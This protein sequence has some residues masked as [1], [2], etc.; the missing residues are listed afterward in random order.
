M[1]L[2]PT[3]ALRG[4]L[5]GAGAACVW[6]AQQPLD[7]LIFASDYDDVELLGKL[8]TSGP[9][10]PLAGLLLHLQN[11]ALFGAVYASVAPHVPSDLD[12][13]VRGAAAGLA[14]HVLLWPLTTLADR[15]HPAR[16]QLPRLRGNR[17]AWWQAAWRHA[18][19]GAVLGELERRLNEPPA[20]EQLSF[21]FG[22]LISSNGS[23]RLEHVLGA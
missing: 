12:P 19:F 16:D 20:P 10:W 14:E 7:R 11:G 3:R 18:L 9:E 22:A 13:R 17:R 2:D 4:A 23:G 15:L 5:A 21:D 1:K 6:A 8:V